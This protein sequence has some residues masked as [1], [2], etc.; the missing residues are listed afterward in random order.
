MEASGKRSLSS[1]I[2]S[3]MGV[4]SEVPVTFPPGASFEATRPLAA[5]S[6][7]AERTMG[8]SGKTFPGHALSGSERRRNIQ[9]PLGQPGLKPRPKR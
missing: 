7:T 3:D 2:C 9:H 6:V 1:F 5:G 8:I 4:R